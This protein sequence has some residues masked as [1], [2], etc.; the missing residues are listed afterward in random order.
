[1]TTLSHRNRNLPFLHRNWLKATNHWNA[2]MG[3][4]VSSQQHQQQRD[5]GDRLTDGA[6]AHDGPNQV[7]GHAQ[8]A[9]KR[10]RIDNDYDGF[11]LFDDYG[12]TQRALR[13]EVLKITHKDAPRVKNGILN[14]VIAP[15]IR[16]VVY[17]RARCKLT[18]CGY[19]GGEAVVLHVDSQVC[20]IRVFKN[21]A[22]SSPMARFSS[23]RPFHIPEDKIFLERD[24]DAIF[25]LA[26]S[27][28]VLL[29]LESAGDANWPPADLVH[30]SDEDTFYNNRGLPSRQWV[31]TANIADIFSN[32]NRKSVRLRV[33]KQPLSDVATNFLLDMDV[34]WLMPIS[35][36]GRVREHT[37]DILASISV[38]DPHAPP[39]NNNTQPTAIISDTNGILRDFRDSHVNGDGDTTLIGHTNG[40][41]VD[42]AEDLA[43]GE[44]TPGRARRARQDINYNVKQMWNN[45]V[46]RETRKRRKLGDEHGQA[47]EHTIT[48]LLPPEQVHTDKFACLL[49]GAENDRLSQLRAH[50]LSHPQY[51][52]HFEYRPKA[53]GHYVTVKPS[54]TGHSS[55]LRPRVYQLGLPVKP[56]DL[57]KY[58]NGD[59]SWVTSRLGPDNGREVFI[60]ETA[61]KA[62]S[63]KLTAKRTRKKVLVP[64][65]KQPLFDTLSKVQLQ[66][67][68]PVPQHPIDDA[69]LLLKHRDNL[70]DFIDLNADEKEYFQEWDTF[71]LR[72]HISS[73]QYLPRHFLRFVRESAAW[74]VERPGRA[75][76]F[77]KHVAT[78][79][80]RRVLPDAVIFEATQLLNDARS[81]GAGPVEGDREE[82]EPM[83]GVVGAA[84]SKASGGCCAQ[85]GGAVPVPAMLVCV[86]KECKNRLY[87]SSCV[88]NPDEAVA[89]R[90]VWKCKAC[91]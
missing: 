86:N 13:I 43:E 34:R 70:Q 35:S 18:I 11:P 63:H 21:P 44:L 50:Y 28:S 19:K 39:A 80:A 48:Y 74:I 23:I 17:V 84:R 76:E 67:G 72:Q 57:D 54:A 56:L 12:A 87:H 14:G 47:D 78:L 85:C 42:H 75:A 81:Q 91:V 29:E 1:M 65:T 4:N 89:R 53:G 25:G 5:S 24:D 49:C 32:R 51:D 16:D 2:K 82:G 26:N 38:I 6:A 27:Y 61:P 71:V 69:W 33:K 37:K 45:A 64:K 60:G 62:A 41:V 90:R 20:D 55:P 66:P 30:V 46:G 73:E 31:L 79:L 22:G 88:E 3:N 58:V 77:S 68:T 7:P 40:S 59:D 83:A 36:Q 15:N 9:A 52:F 10:R 8:R